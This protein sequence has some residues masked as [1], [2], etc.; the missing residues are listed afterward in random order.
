[1]EAM[2]FYTAN[3][4]CD[5]GKLKKCPKEIAEREVKHMDIIS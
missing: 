1:M 3:G 4:C 5:V 2:S